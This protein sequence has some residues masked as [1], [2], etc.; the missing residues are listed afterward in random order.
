MRT[1]RPRRDDGR[2]DYTKL[3][4]GQGRVKVGDGEGEE[5]NGEEIDDDMSNDGVSS[6]EVCVTLT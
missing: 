6:R 4:S 5:R 3:A 2:I 1:G